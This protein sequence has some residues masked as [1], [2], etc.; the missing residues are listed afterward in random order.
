MCVA[1]PGPGKRTAHIRLGS[2]YESHLF[3]LCFCGLSQLE[4][5]N[6][7]NHNKKL[8]TRK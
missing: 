6:N 2:P 1:L 3:D 8:K 5:V 4:V 7:I